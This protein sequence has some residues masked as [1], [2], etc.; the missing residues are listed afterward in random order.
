[1]SAQV[2]FSQ[3]DLFKAVLFHLQQRYDAQHFMLPKPI[4]TK[5]MANNPQHQLEKQPMAYQD[6]LQIDFGDKFWVL[7]LGTHDNNDCDHYAAD[8]S[9]LRFFNIDLAPQQAVAEIRHRLGVGRTFLHSLFCGRSNGQL[10]FPLESMYYEVLQSL[11]TA[12]LDSFWVRPHKQS[13][14]FGDGLFREPRVRPG[15]FPH[16]TLVY[17]TDLA[18]KVLTSAP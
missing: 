13:M 7:C 3:Q 18:D 2:F 4:T 16:D 8:L 9:A 6:F 10:C 11:S 5:I 17:F 12:E 14:V 1:M 15:Y